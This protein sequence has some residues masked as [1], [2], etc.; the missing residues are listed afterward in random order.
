MMDDIRERR[1]ARRMARDVLRHM[2]SPCA[3]H[4]L[5]ADKINRPGR[6][7]AARWVKKWPR[8]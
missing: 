5:A 2:E 3:V 6:K 1:M 4:Y 8:R 7:R